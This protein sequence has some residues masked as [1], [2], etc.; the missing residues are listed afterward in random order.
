MKLF[1]LPLVATMLLAGTAAAADCSAPDRMTTRQI[2]VCE[3]SHGKIDA[4]PQTDFWD[5]LMALEESGA[6]AVLDWKADTE[7]ILW[8]FDK[9]LAFNGL[10]GLTPPENARL[11]EIGA[12]AW[13]KSTPMADLEAHL[14]N[15]VA[16]RGGKLLY[17]DSG[18][19][20]YVYAILSDC[21]YRRWADV[22]LGDEFAA[23][24]V[25]NN[26][27]D[28]GFAGNAKSDSPH[29]ICGASE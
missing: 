29:A 25:D 17:I 20:S 15:A 10:A 5:S 14:Q 3:V 1:A 13:G 27:M 24:P 8:K 21:L 28:L 19:D 11:A 22:R 26:V 16:A 7:D 18:S 4:A 6:V 9:M 12:A 2:F 23:I